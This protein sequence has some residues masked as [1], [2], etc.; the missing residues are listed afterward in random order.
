MTIPDRAKPAGRLLIAALRAYS[1]ACQP[2]ALTPAC[3]FYRATL[4]GPRCGRE[5]RQILSQAGERPDP[6]Q[7]AVP[8]LEFDA[9]QQ[10]L[11]DHRLPAGKRATGSLLLALAD[12]LDPPV[13][14]ESPRGL[15]DL[16]EELHRRGIDAQSVVTTAVLPGV[17]GSLAVLSLLP[18]LVDASGLR[19][20]AA[21]DVISFWLP[22]SAALDAAIAG[23]G[24]DRAA[25]RAAGR[26]AHIN[27]A[28]MV[29]ANPSLLVDATVAGLVDGAPLPHGLTPTS[30][31]THPRLSTRL[32]Y[33]LSDRFLNRLHRWLT[34][35]MP[36]A[37]R[38][39]D[40]W[41]TPDP[42]QFLTMSMEPLPPQPHA[43]WMWD[44]F[45]LTYPR[46]WR[47]E[48]VRA[49][50]SFLHGR[51]A[52]P[53]HQETMAGRTVRLH[54]L[55]EA[56]MT[57]R[58][59]AGASTQ[60]SGLSTV[61]FVEVAAARLRHGRSEEAAAVFAGVVELRPDDADA[62]NNYGFCLL[63]TDP[64]RALVELE[65]AR[66]LGVRPTAINAANRALALHLL[67][68]DADAVT[69]ATEALATADRCGGAFLWR[70]E[71]NAQGLRLQ[72]N[73]DP[74]ATLR[75]MLRHLAS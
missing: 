72:E 74:I 52:P 38:D 65:R 30:I 3:P 9:R 35:Q 17:A 10:Y 12:A 31:M 42:V 50:W 27:F 59:T 62:R 21:D 58:P 40:G 26:D 66:D 1:E 57:S 75:W 11:T 51:Q 28:A 8:D 55:A 33:A 44:R 6:V 64:E 68:R 24:G 37:I 20:P 32:T 53:C 45:T 73:A 4:D 67:G 56:A 14:D 2:P 48:S 39:F 13:D 70:H 63:P 46:E 41:S 18:D 47:W 34:T 5:C 54:D 49:E 36:D 22:W 60:P 15:A 29:A 23:E 16:V 61:D 7:R 69:V 19:L 71:C 43:Q 25:L